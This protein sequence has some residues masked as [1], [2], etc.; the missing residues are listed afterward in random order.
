MGGEVQVAH[1]SALN[2][3][4]MDTLL[5]AIELQS[6]VLDLKANPDARAS[7]AVVEGKMERAGSVATVLI[8]RGTLNVGDVFVAGTEWG[9]VRALVNDQGQQVKQAT[10]ATPIEVLGLN[11]TPVADE[12]IVVESE[13][14]A[15]GC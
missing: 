15:R 9:K 2:G 3:D 11:G 6:E 12:F 5:E 14:G 7:G 4:G 1:V 8:Q 10:P 13:A